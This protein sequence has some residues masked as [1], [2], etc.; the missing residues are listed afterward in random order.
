MKRFS[1]GQ[2]IVA[3]LIAAVIAIVIIYRQM[4]FF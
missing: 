2:I 1:T 4:T 3:V